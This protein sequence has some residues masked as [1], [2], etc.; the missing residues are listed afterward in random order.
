MPAS[1]MRQGLSLHEKSSTACQ[2]DLSLVVLVDLMKDNI[3]VRVHHERLA[4]L[5]CPMTSCS[6]TF[7]CQASISRHVIQCHSTADIVA[8]IN[9]R[10]KRSANT[11]QYSLPSL[12][13]GFNRRKLNEDNELAQQ[14]KEL[15]KLLLND[16]SL[17]K[18]PDE[19]MEITLT[20]CSLNPI[21]RDGFKEIGLTE[22][23]WVIF[24]L[25]MTIFR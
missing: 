6:K 21:L 13:S 5:P 12:L 1:G 7:T 3:F 25:V 11:R 17:V 20:D 23:W 16:E 10:Q 19:A 22:L 9:Q 14:M 4:R 8:Q 18:V 24:E 15:L 2:V